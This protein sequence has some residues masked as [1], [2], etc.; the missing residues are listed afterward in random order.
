MS[1]LTQ[2][3]VSLHQG[4]PEAL[5]DLLPLVYDELKQLAAAK[6]A[7]ERPGQ[8][9]QATVLV[10]DAWQ[11]LVDRP[12]QSWENRRHFFG[13]AAEAMRRI[14]IDNARRKAREKHGGHLERVVL[15]EI[16][17][18]VETDVEKLV[19]VH[20]A[21][22]QFELKEPEKAEIVKLH[23]FAGLDFVE[24]A[25]IL[26][27]SERTVRRYWGFSKLWLYQAIKRR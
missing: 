4:N 5:N 12:D 25:E 1:Q 15:D 19:H 23:F 16:V 2:I 9:L 7:R 22:E 3:L 6:M 11:R 24:I 8:T 20:E 18:P 26:G 17:L 13:A 21:L 27:L 10:H 14:L